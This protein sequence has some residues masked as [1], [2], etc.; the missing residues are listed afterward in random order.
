MIRINTYT[1]IYSIGKRGAS[2]RI[3]Y[4]CY[5]DDLYDEYHLKERYY[6]S[7]SK[8]SCEF[9]FWDTVGDTRFYQ[10]I[11]SSVRRSNITILMYYLTIKQEP[12][13]QSKMAK[14]MQFILEIDHKLRKYFCE[15]ID[16]ILVGMIEIDEDDS[17]NNQ[18]YNEN[19]KPY[20]KLHQKQ[21]EMLNQ[22][23]KIFRFVDYYNTT[24]SFPN[25]NNNNNDSDSDSSGEFNSFIIQTKI[26]RDV[27]T[28]QYHKSYF[29]Y[30]FFQIATN[31]D[32]TASNVMFTT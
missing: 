24:Y 23:T 22:T 28:I 19:P 3:D 17:Y 18:D 27:C 20:D 2:N 6:Y 12:K 15:K 29:I 5:N 1:H 16:C 21:I 10:N 25:N 9:A 26:K 13:C 11:F 14:S 31:P 7:L 8:I 30:F 32:I 4:K